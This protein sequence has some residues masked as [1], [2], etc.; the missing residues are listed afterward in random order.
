MYLINIIIIVKL[1]LFSDFSPPWPAEYTKSRADDVTMLM[2]SLAGHHVVLDL[3]DAL[4]PV[5]LEV[6]LHLG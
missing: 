3:L 4:F 2:T 5:R 6:L 1:Y